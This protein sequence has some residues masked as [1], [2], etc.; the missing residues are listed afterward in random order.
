[1]YK[2]PDKLQN[3]KSDFRKLFIKNSSDFQTFRT[4]F[5]HLASEA[6]IPRE[7]YVQE[8]FGKLFFKMKSHVAAHKTSKLFKE[9]EA[10]CNSVALTLSRARGNGKKQIEFNK[11]ASAASSAN[12]NSQTVLSGTPKGQTPENR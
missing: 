5:L 6:K 11:K 8:F 10:I 12:P 1:V 7:D 3:A 2:D 4:E 9:F